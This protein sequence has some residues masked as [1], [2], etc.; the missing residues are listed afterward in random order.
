MC[1]GT[2][3]DH[4]SQ[5]VLNQL[6]KAPVIVLAP[7]KAI[8]QDV[9]A[10]VEGQLAVRALKEDGV[11]RNAATASVDEVQFEDLKVDRVRQR[12]LIVNRIN[13]TS[14][15][16][17]DLVSLLKPGI[18][19]YPVLQIERITGDFRPRA[20]GDDQRVPPLPPGLAFLWIGGVEQSLL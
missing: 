13:F 19:E 2:A 10:G 15:S 17:G 7:S 16:I 5:Q 8:L 18:L 9:G 20:L 1:D 12:K 11:N 14:D 4:L 3:A 6:L